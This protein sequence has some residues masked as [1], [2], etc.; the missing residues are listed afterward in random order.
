M[1]ERLEP[2]DIALRATELEYRVTISAQ[3]KKRTIFLKVR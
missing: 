2:L 3:M 1:P